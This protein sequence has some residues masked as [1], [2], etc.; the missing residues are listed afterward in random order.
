M[1]IVR[2]VNSLD[3]GGVEKVFEVVAS[4]YSG[5]KES[6]VFI[7]L[8][9][10][11][12]AADFIASLG[13]RVIILGLSPV[14]PNFRAIRKLYSIFQRERP[15][16]IHACGAEGNF[17]GLIAA[18]LARV[19]V[20]IGEEIG[21]P[22]H[23]TMAKIIFSL[24]YGRATRVIAVASSVRDYL[25]KTGEVA[26]RKVALVYNPVDINKFST[27]DSREH[28]N[29]FVLLTVCRL[30]PIKNLA[31]LIT[32]IHQ[33][34][35]E[36]DNLRLWIVGDGGIRQDLEALVKSLKLE[37]YVIFYGFQADPSPF[38]AKADGFV[39]PS[40]S[41]GHPVSLVEA[42]VSGVPSIVT[43][44]GGAPEIIRE[45]ESG[46][47]INPHDAR[48]IVKAIRELLGINPQDRKKLVEGARMYATE[49]FSPKAYFTELER[50]YQSI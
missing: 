33:L 14:I 30:H 23:S 39:L 3:F 2:I 49:H 4:Y 37:K 8:G 40:L 19:P 13:Y 50:L 12:R 38:F 48:T 32:C 18:W 24:V 36:Y 34:V 25:I 20:R 11:G 10:G 27:Q 29:E 42:M 46:W 43:Q 9:S 47:L 15:D 22:S 7:A 16:I 26:E 35:P 21:M 45:R 17:H 1:K 6:L 44:V 31:M 41:E 28:S 5:D